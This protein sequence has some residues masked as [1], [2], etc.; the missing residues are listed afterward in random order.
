[1]VCRE[2]FRAAS[3]SSVLKTSSVLSRLAN[4]TTLR[5]GGRSPSAAKL[6]KAG[7]NFLCVRSPV[8]PKI[9][10]AHVPGVARDTSPSL[11]GFSINL[12]VILPPPISAV[13]YHQGG[14]QGDQ[15]YQ[16]RTRRAR[17]QA[18]TANGEP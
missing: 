15:V 17:R 7:I 1:M 5:P 8:A 13:E 18:D 10:I 12:S 16:R 9:T 3:S 6:Y 4:P 11:N 14:V 2:N